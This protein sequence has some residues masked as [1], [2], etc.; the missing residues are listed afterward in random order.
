MPEKMLYD[1]FQS[2]GETSKLYMARMNLQG[3]VGCFC[4]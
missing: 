3:Q 2:N 4:V 1:C